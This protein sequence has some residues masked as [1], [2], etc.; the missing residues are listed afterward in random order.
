MDKKKKNNTL[1]FI[2]L[3]ILIL[4]TA[5]VLEIRWLIPIANIALVWKSVAYLIS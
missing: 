5:V 2:A 3:L 1:I 4:I